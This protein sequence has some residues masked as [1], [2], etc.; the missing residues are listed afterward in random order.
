MCQNYWKINQNKLHWK[1][2]PKIISISKHCSRVELI[3]PLSVMI[4]QSN[5]ITFDLSTT[6]HSTARLSMLAF[7]RSSRMPSSFL[8]PIGGRR[9]RRRL[10]P[11]RPPFE[12][13]LI[14]ARFIIRNHLTAL[15]PLVITVCRG[16]GS[17][18]ANSWRFRWGRSGNL[19]LLRGFFLSREAY[20]GEHASLVLLICSGGGGGCCCGRRVRWGFGNWLRWPS[21]WGGLRS[22][23]AVVVPLMVAIP[24][25]FPI[26]VIALTIGDVLRFSFG[27]A[28]RFH[29]AIWRRPFRTVAVV[30]VIAAW[31]RWKWLL[32]HQNRNG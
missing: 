22:G 18:G 24:I 11:R 8:L 20:A 19:S 17:G 4:T 21:G 15:P 1:I 9:R 5:P 13:P 16:T 25:P 2:L 28:W 30:V 29:L 23:M 31:R 14:V 32:L 7:P 6:Q 3:Q 27:W 12:M 10:V 26:L